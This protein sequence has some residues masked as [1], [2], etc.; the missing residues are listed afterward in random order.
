MPELPWETSGTRDRPR[1]AETADSSEPNTLPRAQAPRTTPPAHL[2]HAGSPP[3]RGNRGLQR[4]EHR[5]TSPSSPHRTSGTRDHLRH[6]ETADSSE[7]DTVPRAQA[8][9]TAPPAH[10]RHAGSPPA[11]RNRGLQRAGHRSTSPSSPHRTSGTPP[12]RAI[13]SGTQKPRV[14]A[15]RTPFHEP[16][17]PTPHLRHISGTRDRPRNAETADS[18]EPDTVPRAE[19]PPASAPARGSTLGTRKPRVPASRTPIREPEVGRAQLRLA[20]TAPA[21]GIRGFLRAGECS[22]SRSGAE[23]GGAYCE[24]RQ[25]CSGA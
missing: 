23:A 4:A 19:G 9:R 20:E 25:E 11:R 7:P 17:L 3:T 15:S 12:A 1:H 18:S 6:A 21:R 14:P 10:L 2:R 24:S 16:K 8:P 5:S 22:A 13:T